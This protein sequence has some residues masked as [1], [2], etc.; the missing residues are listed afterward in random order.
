[1]G[2]HE[3]GRPVVFRNWPFFVFAWACLAL[4]TYLFGLAAV[5]IG[6]GGTFGVAVF[7]AAVSYIVWVLGCHSAVR[8]DGSGVIVDDVLTRH[9]IPW[10]E[11]RRIEVVGGL[12]IEVRGGPYIRTM[13]FGGSLYGVV[14]RY[15]AQR[16]VAARM[17]VAR[18]RLEAGSPR[19]THRRATPQQSGSP[20]GLRWRSWPL[21]RRSPLSGCWPG[22]CSETHSS[23]A[24]SVTFSH[25]NRPGCPGSGPAAFVPRSDLAER[26]RRS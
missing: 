20:R 18:E 5:D 25:P 21:W 10:A 13:M 3:H 2:G 8:M 26:V 11:L 6:G 4:I 1:M 17:N 24:I 7:F 16:K 9:V 22:E 12:V 14:T 19:R 23:P 15:R